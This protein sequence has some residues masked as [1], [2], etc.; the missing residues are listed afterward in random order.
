MIYKDKELNEKIKDEAHLDTDWYCIDKN[1]C[2]GIIAS[3]GG[4]LPSS[5][6]RQL[7][8]PN[9]IIDYFRNLPPISSEII[10][11]NTII[12][13]L[14]TMN[15]KQEEAY[16][17]D[18][19]LMTSKGLYYF[20]KQVLNNYFDFEYIKKA[21]P[22]KILTLNNIAPIFKDIVMQTIIEIDFDVDT[23][24]FVNGVK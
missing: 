24:F 15:F 14:K 13:K 6:I 21:K 20:D 3:A 22:K 8:S 4:L 18:V 19:K 12:E 11:E 23:F 10:L 5:V 2:L 7:N 17:K 16:L 1:G 9:N